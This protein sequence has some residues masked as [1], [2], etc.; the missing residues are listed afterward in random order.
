MARVFRVQKDGQMQLNVLSHQQQPPQQDGCQP[1]PSEPDADSIL[2]TWD[3]PNP[4]T[5]DAYWLKFVASG[6][7]PDAWSDDRFETWT[8]GFI[9][10]DE[11]AEEAAQVVSDILTQPGTTP[12][13]RYLRLVPPDDFT[14]P[15]RFVQFMNVEGAPLATVVN[16]VMTDGGLG[17]VFVRAERGGVFSEFA[18]TQWQQ[19]E[20]PAPPS[21]IQI[22]FG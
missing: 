4:T 8:G 6:S 2:I 7:D 10:G 15:G 3:H 12:A 16:D 17:T 11:P 5:I 18:S 22:Q 20:Q 14:C 21:N 1:T 9:P 19:P 13:P